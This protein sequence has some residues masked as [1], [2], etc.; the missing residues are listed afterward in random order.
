MRPRGSVTG[1]IVIIAI[2]IVF[3]IHAI[4]PQLRI[5]DFLALYWPYFLIAWGV[6]AFAE[7]TV[8]FLRNAPVPVNG[9]SGGSWFAIVFICLAGVMLFE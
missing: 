8:R 3:L 7:V 1:P 6:L 2:G 5:V 4:A 9:I